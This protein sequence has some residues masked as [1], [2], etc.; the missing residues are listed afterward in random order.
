MSKLR[1]HIL[2]VDDEPDVED[3]FRQKF[4]KRLRS[5][6]LAFTFAEN[7]KQALECLAADPRIEVVFTD[8]N[9]PVMDGLSFLSEVK[10][11]PDNP[12]KTVIIS[13]YG[14]LSNIR[15]AMNRGAMDFIVKPID[16]TDLEATLDKALA[17]ADILRR[18]LEAAAAL[19]ATRLEKEVVERSRKAQKDFFDNVT[20]EL[21][22]P[23]TLLLGPVERALA[24]VPEGSARRQLLLARKHGSALLQLID[25]LLDIARID[26]DSHQLMPVRAD[27]SA[28]LRTLCASYTA[29]AEA[30][31]LRFS[32][33]IPD[34]RVEVDFDPQKL[35]KVVDNLLSNAFKFTPA[36][37]TVALT[38]QS[39]AETVEIRVHD[40][41]P[42]IPQADLPHI[43]DRFF[44]A[45]S[46]ATQG[47]R[48]TGIGLALAR[49][50]VELHHGTVS[51]TS[52]TGQG[53]D[54]VV[55]LPLRQDASQVLSNKVPAAELSEAAEALAPDN[56]EIA[57]TE[58]AVTANDTAGLILIA[59][60][61]PEMRAHIRAS[62]GERYRVL[63]AANGRE[64]LEIATSQVPD[65]LI[66]DVMMP[67]MDGIEL[68]AMVKGT[69]E[70][71]HI[72]VILLTARAH[73]TDRLEGLK[74][75][76]D[77]YLA[78]PFHEE[79][80]LTHLHNLLQSREQLREKYRRELLLAPSAPTT[81]SMEDQFLQAVRQLMDTHLGNE[82]FGVSQMAA[83]L[84]MSRKTL[85]RKLSAMTGQ[86][87]NQFIRTF[88][89]EA[90][91]QMLQNKTGPIGEIAFM[92]GF[93]SHSYFTKCF[94][95]AFGMQPSE[96]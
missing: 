15:Q 94:V 44:R 33:E 60:D 16:L 17:E 34:A 57:T 89:L 86:S 81:N 4:R 84:A 26:A 27:L 47:I 56:V 88:R 3:L 92:T 70:T 24:L 68:C 93:G 19:E 72:P 20:H 35:R 80:L 10:A 73:V 36:G 66:S 30:R 83:E 25:E 52:V 5:G 76:A 54:F 50:L 32:M 77:V 85:H 91:R 31:E 64:A 53:A 11:Q 82:H 71:A 6:E 29:H 37:G 40:S 12:V 41:G 13:A 65:I 39:A 63:E 9:M 95:E 49:E 14:D 48:G 8:L 67:E 1:R 55:R 87:P 42:G 90:A 43:F 62:I 69:R 58:P 28:F 18:G 21:R 75:G 45:S 59:E 2:I 61:H 23:L 74:T 38:L 22:T 78:K 7:G 46:D 51:V 96:V 79:E